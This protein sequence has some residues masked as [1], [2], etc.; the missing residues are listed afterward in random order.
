LF[1]DAPAPAQVLGLAVA[2]QW[3]HVEVA[4][5]V[6]RDAGDYRVVERALDEIAETRFAGG[7]EH[8]PAPHDARDRATRLAVREVVGQLVRLPERFAEMP[9]ADAAGDVELAADEVVPL[10]VERGEQRR[11]AGLEIDIRGTGRQVERAD[12]VALDPRRLAHGHA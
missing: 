10:A 7:Q 11:F 2:G 5:A 4:L 9:A 12:G 8:A 1:A 3:I 6:E